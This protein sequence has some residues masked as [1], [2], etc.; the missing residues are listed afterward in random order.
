MAIFWANVGVD[1]ETAKAS[2][3][4]ISA[5]TKAS[6]AV[7][8]SAAHGYSNGD[9]IVL[10]IVGMVEL[11]NQAFRVASVTTDTFALEGVDSTAYNTF[12]SGTA[13]KRTLG[14]SMSTSQDVNASGG[15][16]NFA[17]VT[18]IHD[19]L[20]KRVPTTKSPLSI[21]ITSIY[22]ASDAALVEL[23]KADRST[24]TRVVRLRFSDGSVMIFNAYIASSG[25]PTG[26]TG[27]VVQ[28]PLSF[29]VQGLPQ[30]FA[31]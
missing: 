20:Q 24:T 2:T 15:E 5:I 29:E 13:S 16:P 9:I 25:V 28:T 12:T 21:S 30:F 11:H 1:I 19:T 23:R 31:S 6:P 4:T 27:N 22:D 26:G 8:T 17:D 7:V 10:S 18:T 3:K 14:V